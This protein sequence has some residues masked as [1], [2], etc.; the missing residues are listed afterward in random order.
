MNLNVKF[1]ISDIP[2]VLSALPVTLELTF[3]SLFFRNFTGS[4]LRSL[5]PEKDSGAEAAGDRT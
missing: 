3:A 2:T 4:A 1:M 5:Y